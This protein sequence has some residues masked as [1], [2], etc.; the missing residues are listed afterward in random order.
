MNLTVNSF[1]SVTVSWTNNETGPYSLYLDRATDS[2]FTLNVVS[3]VL[4]SGTTSFTDTL[5]DYHNVYY[6]RVRTV[7]ESGTANSTT[8]TGF[9]AF[10]SIVDATVVALGLEDNR[11]LGFS[12]VDATVV[13]LGLED[14]RHLG[15]SVVDTTAVALGLEDNR[16][17]GIAVV[18]TTS[19]ILVQP[20][21]H[22][23]I[24]I[25]DLTSV[26]LG[27]EYQRDYPLNITD[28][29]LVN[30]YSSW[31][32]PRAGMKAVIKLLT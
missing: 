29:T 27:I 1:T 23:S 22:F 4:A 19:V 28:G 18:D 10:F 15:F 8:A 24:G 3:E 21:P 14:N 31:A 9:L 5:L 26:L 13:A 7:N 6:Y 20:H 32:G 25:L 16:H 2:A 30:M 12:I 17:F 11:H